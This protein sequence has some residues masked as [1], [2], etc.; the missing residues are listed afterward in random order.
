MLDGWDGLGWISLKLFFAQSRIRYLFLDF[1]EKQMSKKEGEL[2]LLLAS[3][4][5]H[6]QKYPLAGVKFKSIN[7]NIIILYVLSS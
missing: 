6:P 4:E 5:R 2:Y 3:R 1:L 7:E